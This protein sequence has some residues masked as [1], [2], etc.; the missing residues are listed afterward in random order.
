[1]SGWS[2]EL[3]SFTCEMDLA[4]TY[5]RHGKLA[6]AF[7][8]AETAWDAAHEIGDSHRMQEAADLLSD[9][10]VAATATEAA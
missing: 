2:P 10:S 8:A 5:L 9:I 1:M 3:H 7:E 6:V 4:R